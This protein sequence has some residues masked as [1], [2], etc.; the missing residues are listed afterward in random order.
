MASPDT[1]SGGTPPSSSPAGRPS[2]SPLMVRRGGR[3]GSLRVKG[4]VFLCQRHCVPLRP[5]WPPVPPT[6]RALP[7][8]RV[9]PVCSPVLLLFFFGVPVFALSAAP[10]R[11]ACTPC[12][13]P[14]YP[15]P[16][17]R[18]PLTRSSPLPSS[19]SQSTLPVRLPSLSVPR[20]HSCVPPAC[21]TP[22]PLRRPYPFP[23]GPPHPSVPSVAISHPIMV[24]LCPVC[25]GG[26]GV[27]A[28]WT[29]ALPE[30]WQGRWVPTHHEPPHLPKEHRENDSK[31]LVEFPSLHLH[32]GAKPQRPAADQSPRSDPAWSPRAHTSLHLA[33]VPWRR[34]PPR[35]GVVDPSEQGG[36]K[37]NGFNAAPSCLAE[38]F[39]AM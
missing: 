1:P 13:S 35:P 29:V 33:G 24:A 18:R 3:Y 26:G 14:C 23:C 12:S 25:G 16:A 15:C 10:A 19:F 2:I 17:T 8:L 22:A 7:P 37:S 20:C 11:P 38:S 21:S 9:L 32:C 31:M 39:A 28:D 34:R 30:D 36:R 5:R 6:S 27:S 4:M